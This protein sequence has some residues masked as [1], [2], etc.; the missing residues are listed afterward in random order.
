MSDVTPP[1]TGVW[2][3]TAAT[4]AAVFA[5]LRLT[6]GDVDQARI[7][8]LIP[9]A[10][11]NIDA[12]LDGEVAVSGP[13][14]PPWAQAALELETVAMYRAQGNDIDPSVVLGG[15][16]TRRDALVGGPAVAALVGPHKTRYGVA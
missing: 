16:P 3:D 6:D 5:V 7:E 9:A 11:G 12:K 8:A 1:A 2:W 15:F 13:P 10:A 4:L 14:P